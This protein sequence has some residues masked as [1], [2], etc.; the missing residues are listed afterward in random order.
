MLNMFG[1]FSDTCCVLPPPVG[2][3]LAP[4]VYQKLLQFNKV[5]GIVATPHSIVE[6]YNNESTRE[7]LKSLEF[8]TYLGATLDR[9]VGDALCEHT[10]LSSVIGSTE[11]GGRFSFHPRDRKLWYSWQFIPEHH[12]R[13]VP[14]ED[15]GA[16]NGGSADSNVYRVFVDRPPGGEP[17]LFQCAFWNLS[18][19]KDVETIDTK[20]LYRPVKDIDGS[21]RWEFVARADDWIKL[22]WMAKFYAQDIETEILR[23]PGI[24]N[25]LVGGMERPAPFVII[26]AKDELLETKSAEELVDDI[27]QTKVLGAN[28]NDIKAMRIPRE[29]VFLAKKEKPFKMNLKEVVLRREVEKDYQAEL[30]EAYENLKK[31]QEAGAAKFVELM[32]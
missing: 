2:T 11:T 25:V 17:S 31:N 3:G 32:R 14:L 29:T 1:V 9:S 24:K 7:S 30:E 20:E 28:K 19:F 23:Y 18:M 4:D 22:I 6:I 8:I 27:Y 10:R 15:T 26:E 5:E 21:T 12:V 16:A 13:L